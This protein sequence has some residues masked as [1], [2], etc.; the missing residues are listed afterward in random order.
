MDVLES[1]RDGEEVGEAHAQ[2]EKIAGACGRQM[3]ADAA[4]AASQREPETQMSR[5]VND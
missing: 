1:P 2:R 3:T 4:V 5:G